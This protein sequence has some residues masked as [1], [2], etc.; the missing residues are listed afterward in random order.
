VLKL[1]VSCTINHS[2]AQAFS[3][4]ENFEEKNPKNPPFYVNGKRYTS[5]V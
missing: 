4:N 2:Y 3:E 1:P 5:Q